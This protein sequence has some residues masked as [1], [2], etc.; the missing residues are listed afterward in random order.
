MNLFR[1]EICQDVYC[2]SWLL[3]PCPSCDAPGEHTHPIE[4]EAAE[5]GRA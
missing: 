4:E 2:S 5:A 1:C 3:D